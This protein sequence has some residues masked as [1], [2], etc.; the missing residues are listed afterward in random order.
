MNLFLNEIA[1]AVCMGLGPGHIDGIA[2]GY[3]ILFMLTI[4]TFILGTVIFVMFRFAKKSK[5]ALDPE[6]IDPRDL[7]N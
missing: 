7:N 3:A 6:F 4:L 2:S 5:M 1:C